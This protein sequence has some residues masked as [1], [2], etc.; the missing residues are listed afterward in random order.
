MR[1]WSGVLAPLVACLAVALVARHLDMV[2]IRGGSMLP[3]LRPGDRLLVLR[4]RRPPRPG[5]VVLAPDPREPSRELVKRVLSVDA[6]GVTLRGDNPAFSTDARTFG[7]VTPERARWRVVARYWPIGR[8]GRIGRVGRRQSG[9]QA[10][11]SVS[12][13]P[14]ASEGTSST[15]VPASAATRWR[16]ASSPGR[17]VSR[18]PGER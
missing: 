4:L 10:R 12:T 18:A 6:R 14:A 13:Q 1:R 7:T 5:E 2:Q 3:A 8:I 15:S 9:P 16:T 17:T 11:I